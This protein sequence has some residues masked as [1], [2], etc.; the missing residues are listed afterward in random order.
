MNINIATVVSS[1]VQLTLF[2][3][4]LSIGLREGFENLTLLWRRPSLLI[5][6]LVASLVLVPLAS[7][8]IDAIVPMG[9]EARI[10]MAGMAICP[11]APMI[12]RKLVNLKGIPALA[13]SFQITT[14][15][16][17]ILA[18]PLWIL[19]IN[20]LYFGSKTG[21]VADV[22]EQIATVQLIPILLGLAIRKWWPKLASNL[23]EPAFKISSC[24]LLV[25]LIII[26]VIYLPQIAQIGAVT[27]LGVVLFIAAT[28]VIGHYL[29]GPDPDTRITIALA[30]ST[31][32]AGLALDLAALNFE[33][34]RL[35]LGTIAAIAL[36]SLVGGAIYVNLYRKKITHRSRTRS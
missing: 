2:L 31:R 27:V 1:Y 4:M 14:S 12:Y 28:I 29:G 16:L 22:T 21:S 25:A 33:A 24:L 17:A 23:L 10:A 9:T 11:G 18:V 8:V 35:I 5:R 15:L 32:N 26:L 6:C 3:L 20:V 13:G 34:N 30:N 7:M 36:L 19:I